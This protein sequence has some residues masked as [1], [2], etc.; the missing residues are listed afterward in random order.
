MKKAIIF[1]ACVFL[2]LGM[3]APMGASALYNSQVETETEIFY[4]ASLDTGAVLF[5]QDSL[6]QTAPASLTKIVTAIVAL[7][8]C[9]DLETVITVKEQS[10]R[11]LDG[12]GSS[13]AGIKPGEE[14]TM[15]NLLYCLLVSSANEAATIIADYIG[16]GSVEKFVQMMNDTVKRIGCKNTQFK[17]PHGLDEDGHYSCAQDVATFTK[18]AMTFPVFNEIT[19]VVKYTLPATNLQPE[20]TITTTNKMKLSNL[21][22]YYVPEIK[23]VKTGSTTNAGRCVVT[24]ATKNGYSYIAVMM[25]APFYDHDD[26]G[27]DENF[28]FMDCKSILNWIFNNIKLKVVAEPTKIITVVDVKYSWKVDHLRLVPAENCVALVPD[29]VDSASVSIE[30]IAETMPEYVAAPIKKGDMVGEAVVKY[31]NEEIARIKL[32]AAEDVK[33][34][35]I[36]F[37]FGK[38]GDF[39]KTAGFKIFTAIIVFFVLFFIGAGIYV[40]RNKKRKRVKVFNYRDIR[41]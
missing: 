28:A 1:L 9:K 32:V 7:E 40:N 29:N 34:S 41:R 19:D 15:R 21:E 2:F 12:T 5:E 4:V 23:G 14:M 39:T 6:R 13:M 35:L 3:Y 25:K 16:G 17:N 11:M 38:L 22:E 18:H 31:A 26:D 24:T 8:N 36:L 37:V 30:P 27:Y 10:I 20:R 33:R